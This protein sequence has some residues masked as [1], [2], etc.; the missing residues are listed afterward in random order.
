MLC[1]HHLN[2]HQ[3]LMKKLM[4]ELIDEANQ[5]TSQL[6]A[7]NLADNR[8]A[9]FEKL[10][11]WRHNSMLYIEQL[12][13]EKLNDIDK[14]YDKSNDEFEQ[15]KQKKLKPI[16]EQMTFACEQQTRKKTL[17]SKL[18]EMKIIV[19][20]DKK[21]FDIINISREKTFEEIEDQS[22]ELFNKEPDRI[23]QTKSNCRE[24]ASSQDF[25]LLG[26]RTELLL[27]KNDGHPVGRVQWTM[28]NNGILQD[29][30]YSEL[31]KCFLI[32]SVHSVFTLTTKQPFTLSKIEQ[33][34]P[35]DKKR[36]DY[37]TCTSQDTLFLNQTLG[38]YIDK[39]STVNNYQLVK[40]YNKTDLIQCDDKSIGIIH[41]N[42]NSIAM[43]IWNKQDQTRIDV[44]DLSIMNRLYKIQHSN[45]DDL[46]LLTTL[47]NEQWLCFNSK[48]SQL[49]LIEKTG[50]LRCI[51]QENEMCNGS[52]EILNGTW[53]NIENQVILGRKKGDHVQLEIYKL[54]T[55]M[56]ISM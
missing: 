42:D 47:C 24:F 38:C 40:R 22:I 46:F 32:L 50:V 21:R 10:K 4:D 48:T 39:I 43:N 44:F 52:G 7:I 41:T 33:L 34:Q 55:T 36:F 18:E 53:I 13:D 8:N 2:E 49:Y 15:Y 56:S 9:L 35:H 29:M 51:K 54:N 20:F 30:C 1:L 19:Q 27:Y 14:L 25:T 5:E 28:K 16:I 3:E 6:Q 12:Y 37:L 26:N 11:Q 31:L 23:I 17:T 45:N